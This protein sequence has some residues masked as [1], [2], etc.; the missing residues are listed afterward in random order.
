[1][2]DIGDKVRISLHQIF[3]G[4]DEHINGQIGIIVEIPHDLDPYVV[5]EYAVLIGNVKYGVN[6]SE[7]VAVNEM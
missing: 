7:L 5:Y 4:I 1:M 2:F 6:E 3:D